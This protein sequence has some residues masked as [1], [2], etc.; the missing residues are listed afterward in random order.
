[1]LGISQKHYSEVERGVTG[2]SVKHLI[3]VSDILEVSLDYLLKG[4][5]FMPSGQQTQELG[6][7][8]DI[9]YSTTPYTRQQIIQLA[10]IAQGIERYAMPCDKES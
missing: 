4:S 7:L 1:M 10:T 9:F 6:H 8:G 2:L 5:E 3:Q